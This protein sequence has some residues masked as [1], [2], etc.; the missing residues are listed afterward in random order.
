MEGQSTQR[1]ED[2]GQQKFRQEIEKFFDKY[3]D[4]ENRRKAFLPLAHK[5]IEA[6]V[7]EESVLPELEK[8]FAIKSKGEFVNTALIMLRP[9][10]EAQRTDPRMIERIRAE[11][12]VEQGKF[13]KLNEV[14]SYGLSGERAHIHLSPSKEL[15]REI[16]VKKYEELIL[17]GLK[18]LA[19]IVEKD[20]NIQ[21]IT[22]TSPVVHNNPKRMAQFHFISRGLID[23]EHREKHWPG[24]KR[25]VEE[26][27]IPREKFLAEYLKKQN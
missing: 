25:P 26:A 1:Q 9:L 7:L 15:V 23:E 21:E 16:G 4:A 11:G 10:W 19:I 24:E 12:F 2:I 8:W 3:E 14:L 13:I 5:I 20:E 22:A 27:Y 17:D 18:K 6:G